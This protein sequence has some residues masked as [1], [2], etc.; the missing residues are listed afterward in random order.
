MFSK[1]LLIAA[2]AGATV[3]TT[4]QT[5]RWANQG[6]PQTMDPHSQNESLTNSINNHVYESLVGRGDNLELVPELAERWQQTGPLTWRVWLRKG[7]K[8]HDGSP[9]TADDVIF[10]AQR[11][12]APCEAPPGRSAP[13]LPHPF[14]SRASVATRLR[15]LTCPLAA[16]PERARGPGTPRKHP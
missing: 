11:V 2:L 9:F 10:S 8:F 4:A 7:V 16:R 6:D 1:I 14:R 12:R 5:L 15:A 13:L 3:T